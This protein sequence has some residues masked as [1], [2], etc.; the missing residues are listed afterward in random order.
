M[1]SHIFSKANKHIEDSTLRSQM[2]LK[3]FCCHSINRVFDQEYVPEVFV[4]FFN[5]QR[6]KLIK[7]D[8]KLAD[9]MRWIEQDSV[10][11]INDTVRILC[12]K[13]YRK[14]K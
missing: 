7:G 12:D 10:D 9:V 2:K 3:I 14:S 11:R 1:L 6:K 8:F 13:F 4:H 5:W